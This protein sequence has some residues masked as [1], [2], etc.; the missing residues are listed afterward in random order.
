MSE[1]NINLEPFVA[2]RGAEAGPGCL[3]GAHTDHAASLEDDVEAFF[4]SGHADL[5]VQE[6]FGS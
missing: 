3:S 5:R 6:G 4:G 2:L 1:K